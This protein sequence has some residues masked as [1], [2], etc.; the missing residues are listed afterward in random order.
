MIQRISVLAAV[1]IAGCSTTGHP[2]KPHREQAIETMKGAGPYTF[3]CDAQAGKTDSRN[4][5]IPSGTLRVTGVLQILAARKND[6]FQASAGIELVAPARSAAAALQLLVRPDDPSKVFIAFGAAS[7]QPEDNVFA[8][9]PLTADPT[10]F[11]LTVD[12][13]GAV[14]G[15]FGGVASPQPLRFSDATYLAIGCS[16]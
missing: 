5:R 12:R 10:P 6:V 2:S 15:S 8:S 4:I 11:A 14:S 13:S 16:T 9:M 1:L 3:D 7:S